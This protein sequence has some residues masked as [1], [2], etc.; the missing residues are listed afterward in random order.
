MTL[1]GSPLQLATN[2]IRRRKLSLGITSIG[3]AVDMI[4]GYVLDTCLL[5]E[6]TPTVAGGF[7]VYKEAS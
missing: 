5:L 6:M 2:D 7:E 4:V 1:L 3:F